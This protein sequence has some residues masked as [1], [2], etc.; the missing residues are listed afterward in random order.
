MPIPPLGENTVATLPRWLDEPADRLSAWQALRIAKTMF[1]VSCGQ[2]DDVRDLGVE[3]LR[4]NAGALAGTQ[5]DHGRARVLADR[6]VRILRELGP[7]SRVD[8]CVEVAAGQSRR[9]LG[10]LLGH[11]DEL[12]AAVDAQ[13]ID[14]LRQALAG[15]GEVD[16]QWRAVAVLTHHL[17]PAMAKMA[18]T[19]ERLMPSTRTDAAVST[20]F[21]LSWDLIPGRSSSVQ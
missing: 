8:D 9:R 1:S 7:A 12:D 13:R 19:T 21:G 3:R 17:P 4:Q 14:D 2:R 11:P 6:R 15:A 5:Q 18:L 20:P 10:H 16:A